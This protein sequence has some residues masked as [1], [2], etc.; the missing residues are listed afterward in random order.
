MY[1]SFLFCSVLFF[2]PLHLHLHSFC[3]LFLP[4]SSVLNRTFYVINQ[5]RLRLLLAKIKDSLCVSVSVCDFPSAAVSFQH[6]PTLTFCHFRCRFFQWRVELSCEVSRLFSPPFFLHFTSF[7]QS[8]LITQQM[9][10]VAPRGTRQI[11]FV[12]HTHTHTHRVLSPYSN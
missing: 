1:T 3:A 11:N 9:M 6:A 2:Y 8:F 12:P 5:S 7:S 4:H 10:I